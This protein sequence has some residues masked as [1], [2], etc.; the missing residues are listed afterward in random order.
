MYLIQNFNEIK[1]NL[2]QF[3]YILLKSFW[4]FKKYSS[5]V[6]RNIFRR[7]IIK[8]PI[9]KILFDTY[10]SR[11]ITHFLTIRSNFWRRTVRSP[12]SGSMLY[13]YCPKHRNH[14]LTIWSNIRRKTARSPI[15]GNMFHTYY[16]KHRSICLLSEATSGYGP[17]GLQSPGTCSILTFQSIEPILNSTCTA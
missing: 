13:V 5:L 12:I 10:Y 11:H 14:L 4:V 2:L 8:F 9:S 17:W 3:T 6:T 15:S 7:R 16:P 1:D